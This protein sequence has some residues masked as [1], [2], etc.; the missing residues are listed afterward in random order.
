VEKADRR[1]QIF[2]AALAVFAEKGY[3]EAGISDIIERAGIARGTFYLYFESKRA[4]FDDILARIFEQILAQ[5]RPIA[6]PVPWDAGS[7]VGQVRDNATRLARLMLGQRE[8]VRILV[9]EAGLDEPARRRL[10]EFYGQ[11][12]GWVTGALDEGMRLGIV[13]PCRPAIAAHALIGMLRGLIWAW[14]EGIL[15]LDEEGFVGEVL[16]MASGGVLRS[17]ERAPGA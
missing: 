15:P 5:I 9:S 3:H 2:T 6:I 13:R 12:A 14:V 10:A 1:E 8:L 7:V 4:I 16:D 17:S 11:L